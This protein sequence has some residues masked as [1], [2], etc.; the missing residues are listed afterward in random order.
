MILNILSQFALF[1]IYFIKGG[2]L[3]TKSKNFTM[4][5]IL[6]QIVLLY[7]SGNGPSEIA[8]NMKEEKVNR[9]MVY[10]TLKRY[11]ETCSVEDKPRPS[12]P[13]SVYTQ[14]G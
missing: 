1:W 13:T 6:Q 4:N 12:R 8:R 10:R 14:S 11:R 2:S 3:Y 7:T 9:M 5:D